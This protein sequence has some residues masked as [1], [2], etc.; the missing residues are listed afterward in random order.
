MNAF[1][2]T[3]PVAFSIAAVLCDLY[4][5]LPPAHLYTDRRPGTRSPSALHSLPSPSPSPLS[6]LSVSADLPARDILH[7]RSHVVLCPFVP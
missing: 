4:L 7:K 5:C 3:K 2:M 6:L 1:K